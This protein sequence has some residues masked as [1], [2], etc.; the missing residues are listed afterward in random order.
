MPF[1]QFKTA[2]KLPAAEHGGLPANPLD[3]ILGRVLG[4][5]G[6]DKIATYFARYAKDWPNLKPWLPED[7]GPGSFLMDCHCHTGLSDGEGNFESVLA[8]IGKDRL[9]DGLLFTDHIWRL[10]ADG[11]TRIPNEKVLHQSFDA[12]NIVKK[13][14]E[15]KVLPEH[16]VSFPGSAEFVCRGT[17]RFPTRGVE[18][19]GAAL[20]PT[21]IEDHGGLRRIRNLLAEELVSRIHD[22][23]GIAILVHPFYFE[24]AYS[25]TLWREVDAVEMV[26]QTTHMFVEPAARGFTKKARGD[27]PLVDEAF[28][29]QP[30]FGYFAWRARV[31]LQEHP[32]PVVGSSDAHVEVFAGAGCTWCKEPV[33]C[34][35]DF[36]KLLRL[37]HTEGILNPR[38]DRAADIDGII[39]AIWHHW[40]KKIVQTMHSLNRERRAVIP[41][42][43]LATMFLKGMKDVPFTRP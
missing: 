6:L 41:V 4:R 25:P 20:P 23:G 38:W 11:K 24:N 33:T 18:L 37:R 17:A 29:L 5:F 30:L 8:R 35:E 7:L 28:R 31:E 42:L 3:E 16:F 27:L 15:K 21:F 43:K 36:R 26:N 39:D 40:G 22:A 34:I 13:L 19:I 10:G 12:L 9:L 2:S 32:R 14:K 1:H